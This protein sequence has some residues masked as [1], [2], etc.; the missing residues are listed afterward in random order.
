M[1]GVNVCCHADP[2][3]ISDTAIA[4]A[5]S[6]CSVRFTCMETLARSCRGHVLIALRWTDWCTLIPCLLDSLSLLLG[7][8]AELLFGIK[9]FISGDTPNLEE[10]CILVANHRT[11]VSRCGLI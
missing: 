5:F 1:D 8:V 9:I 11:R 3:C 7:S 6:V 2:R 10:C 4:A